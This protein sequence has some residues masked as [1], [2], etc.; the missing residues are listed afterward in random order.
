MINWIPQIIMVLLFGFAI[1]AEG[2]KHGEL[3][4]GKHN[5]W[6]QIIAVVLEAGVL[7]WGGFWG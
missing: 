2:M 3:K 7:W 5:I 1:G 4:T 6:M